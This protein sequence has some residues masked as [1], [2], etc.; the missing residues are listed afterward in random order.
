[1]LCLCNIESTAIE[2]GRFRGDFKARRIV[3]MHKVG[4]R[5][6]LDQGRTHSISSN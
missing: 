1:M 6:D 3:L 5:L 4:L 2:N